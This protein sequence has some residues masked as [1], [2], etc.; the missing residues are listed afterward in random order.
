MRDLNDALKLSL[1]THK[2]Q[3][4]SVVQVAYA[5]LYRQMQNYESI[6]N[7]ELA[8]LTKATNAD[9]LQAKKQNMAIAKKKVRTA[10]YKNNW[11]SNSNK[12]I[13]SIEY[14]SLPWR[15]WQ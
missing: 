14:S 5:D 8:Q 3:N 1:K 6:K 11:K 10:A 9:S 12:Q 7:A 13:A 15:L 2:P 4:E